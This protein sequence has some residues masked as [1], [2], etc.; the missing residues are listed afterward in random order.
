[1]MH[2]TKSLVQE[3]ALAAGVLVAAIFTG[4]VGYVDGGYGGGAVVVHEPDTYIYGGSYESVHDVNVYSHRGAVSR[5]VVHE[6]PHHTVVV[7]DHH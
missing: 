5:T 3:V 7:H 4:C 1:M 2:K 6:T